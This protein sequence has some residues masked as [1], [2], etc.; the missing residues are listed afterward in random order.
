[1]KKENE[2]EISS[3][4]PQFPNNLSHKENIAPDVLKKNINK[5]SRL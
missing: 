2:I 5:I 4:Q 3:D 1:M